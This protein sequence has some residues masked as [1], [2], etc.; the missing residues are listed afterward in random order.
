MGRTLNQKTRNK[1]NT[2]LVQMTSE[3]FARKV[4]DLCVEFDMI[5][6]YNIQ[7]HRDI[8]V[9]ARLQL[10]KGFIEVYRNFKTDK[11]AFA[12]IHN[13]KRVYGV[14]NTGYWHEHPYNNPSQH[15]DSDPV[16]IKEF[17]ERVEELLS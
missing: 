15:I 17:L 10:T 3:E 16:N 4:I 12:W 8:I 13:K 2:R 6:D 1:E 9:R 7:I 11:T 5:K 14:D